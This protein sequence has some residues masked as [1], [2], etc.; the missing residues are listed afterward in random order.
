MMWMGQHCGYWH[1]ALHP[2]HESL[3][4]QKW[5]LEAALAARHCAGDLAG[6]VGFRA[7]EAVEVWRRDVHRDADCA[8]PIHRHAEPA[9]G[10]AREREDGFRPG[11]TGQSHP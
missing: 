4:L 11:F 3:N 2:G 9:I 1:A 6:E 8:A 10:A 7:A 5:V